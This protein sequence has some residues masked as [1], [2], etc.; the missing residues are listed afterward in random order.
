MRAISTAVALAVAAL[1]V[2]APASAAEAPAPKKLLW[3]TVNVCAVEG[4]PN[5]FGIRASMPGNGTRQRMYMRFLAQAYSAE[6]RRYV[7]TGARS[8]WIRVGSA[9]F[10]SRQSGYSFDFPDPPVGARYK[11]RGLVRFQWRE[12]RARAGGQGKRWVVVKRRERITRGGRRGV[13]G[14][15]PPGRSD[16]VCLIDR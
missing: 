13:K 4:T 2:P 5:T 14:G 6:K 16:A 12:L 8:T 1:I 7:L 3:A 9:R 15:D 11:L 10:V